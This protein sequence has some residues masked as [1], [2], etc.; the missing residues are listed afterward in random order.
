MST[1]KAESASQLA[2]RILKEKKKEIKN[3]RS[4]DRSSE[5]DC[6][7]GSDVEHRSYSKQVSKSS[8]QELKKKV[9]RTEKKSW[10]TRKYSSRTEIWKSYAKQTAT[11]LRRTEQKFTGTTPGTDEKQ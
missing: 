4:K 3:K 7:D 11:V 1:P 10:R 2:A 5:S 8:E 6:S 9:T